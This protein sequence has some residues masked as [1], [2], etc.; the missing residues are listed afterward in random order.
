M[1]N[2][3]VDGADLTS[4]ANAIR[5]KGGTSAQ[6][7]FPQDF[8]DA[9]QA[10]PTG[11]APTGTKQISITANGTTTEDV[12][13]YANAEITVNVPSGPS[14][15]LITKTIT[16]NGTYNASSDNADGYSSVTVST[17]S[18]RSVL[19]G[20]ITSYVDDGITSIVKYGL[21][22][23]KNLREFICHNINSAIQDCFNGNHNLKIALPKW[24]V[25]N[26]YGAENNTAM[27]ALDLTA[28]YRLAANTFNGC[29]KLATLV[30]RYNGV[31]S[32]Q[33]VNVFAR[34]PFA[35]GGAGG[36]LYVPQ[37]LIASY[38]SATNWSTILGYGSG[39]QNQILP[40][41]G[42]IY[43]TQYADGTAI[44]TT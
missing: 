39:A 31:V 10:I 42:S 6:L 26:S 44:P 35:S 1:S 4:V 32:L 29:T 41:E 13:A 21:Y 40:I 36:T 14:P 3:L 9:V 8:V 12:A 11:I 37:D 5:T 43:E 34:T 25:Y 16:E 33:N 20:S 15:T 28:A 18:A 27:T 30:L 17:A 24:T 2:Y 38:Q 19:N 7:A 23:C 22:N